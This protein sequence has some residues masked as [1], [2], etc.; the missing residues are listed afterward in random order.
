MNTPIKQEHWTDFQGSPAGGITE[1]T[2][3]T[4]SWQH[5]PL[6]RGADRK[7]PNGAFVEN[8]I[9]AVIGRIEFYQETNFMC[10]E[11]QAAL[12]CLASA[13]DVL[14]SRTQ[15]REVAGTEGTHKETSKK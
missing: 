2:G 14:N 9:K 11:N 10:P 6:G 3:F 7:E 8:V 12:D 15:R 1:G 4:I 13:L 5:G